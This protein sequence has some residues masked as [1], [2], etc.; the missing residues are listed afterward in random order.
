MI[1]VRRSD[2][3]ASILQ[4]NRETTIVTT[5][6]KLSTSSSQTTFHISISAASGPNI[7]QHVPNLVI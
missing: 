4:N 7:G 2:P 1:T 6:Y 5:R 3:S